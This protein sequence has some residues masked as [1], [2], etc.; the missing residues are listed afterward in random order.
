MHRVRGGL[1]ARDLRPDP[2]RRR[3]RA[4]A[5]LPIKQRPI[6]NDGDRPR[7]SGGRRSGAVS[8]P[9]KGAA[10]Q[11]GLPG[12]G[13]RPDRSVREVDRLGAPDLAMPASGA[14]PG[15]HR[16]PT[17]TAAG[18]R[19]DLARTPASPRPPGPAARPP[20]AA[21]P[22]SSGPAM[23]PDLSGDLSG[24]G[25]DRARLRAGRPARFPRGH[26]SAPGD[27]PGGECRP[28]GLGPFGPV[29]AW[30]RPHRHRRCPVRFAAD[31]SG[32]AGADAC[33]PPPGPDRAGCAQRP[34]RRTAR[35]S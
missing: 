12:A 24:R 21:A 30:P 7:R 13:P 11:P 35:P 25:G 29:L 9:G 33:R 22:P 31:R 27:R 6:P 32:P 5:S 23:T 4:P 15:P 18:A 3:C 34:A 26:P 19:P 2:G 10:G 8:R 17:R 1:G 16:R 14:A 28:A 20:G